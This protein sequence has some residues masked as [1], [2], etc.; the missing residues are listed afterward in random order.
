MHNSKRSYLLGVC[1]L[2]LLLALLSI[3]IIQWPFSEKWRFVGSTF[4]VCILIGRLVLACASSPLERLA[5]GL[6][7]ATTDD[8]S[9]IQPHIYA[10]TSSHLSASNDSTSF[11]SPPSSLSPP[12]SSSS[13]PSKSNHPIM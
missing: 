11:P 7:S 5:I 4:I 8:A 13:F 10:F 3:A 1:I 6:V 12:V 9:Y 2:A